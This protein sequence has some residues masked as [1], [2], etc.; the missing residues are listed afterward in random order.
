MATIN[1]GG[2]IENVVTR[3]EFPLSK[4]R[5]VLKN[6]VIAVIG[7]GVQGPGQSLN[8]KDNGFNVIVGQRKNS[9]SWERA[10]SDGW[11][12]GKDLFEIE[13]ACRRGTIIQY[14]LSDA[15]QIASWPVV[16]KHLT[17][18][19]AL[20]FSHGFGIT[21]NDQTGIVPPADVDVILIAPKGSGTS[22]RRLFLEGKGLN[23]SYAV[24]QDATGKAGERVFALGIGVGSG[25]LF[26]T[27]FRK[28]VYSDLTGERGVLMGAIAGIMEAQY[29]LLRKMGHSPSEAFNETVEELSQS[30][31]PLVAENG[32]DWMYA[33]CS[34]TA[35]RGALDWKN[36][37]R[38]AVA[39]VFDKLYESVASGNEARITIEANKQPD[40][41]EKLATELDELHNSE[42]WQ[43]GAMVRKLRPGK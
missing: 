17:K 2:V 27:D 19:K 25:Y 40:Y 42:M 39:P 31:L 43:A 9:S 41:R 1:F 34:T 20:Y 3:D 32:M 5:E 36:R 24:Y 23:S 10:V 37:F 12:E 26:E 33:N 38:D 11:E 15:G 13:E 16:K 14:L 18:G 8:L 4:A 30:L 22:L 35:Q 28:E 6:E 7:Y 21:F 29:N